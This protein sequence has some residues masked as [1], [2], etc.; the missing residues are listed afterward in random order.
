MQISPTC[1]RK[2]HNNRQGNKG[3]G[4]AV[5]L[6]EEGGKGKGNR[7][8]AWKK[9][10]FCRDL[11]W[12]GSKSGHNKAIKFFYNSCKAKQL[13][14][15]VSRGLC[16]GLQEKHREGQLNL[17]AAVQ[18]GAGLVPKDPPLVSAWVMWGPTLQ[19]P[20]FPVPGT[21]GW[22]LDQTFKGRCR[23]GELSILSVSPKL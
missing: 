19:F 11:S 7:T 23:P 17:S 15:L 20:L 16:N 18:Q 8:V 3:C 22:R 6:P 13:S 9:R 12:Q 2:L 4:G 14:G 10:N 1:T 21:W 5:N